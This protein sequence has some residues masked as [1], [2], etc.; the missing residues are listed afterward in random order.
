[1]KKFL[2]FSLI[3][4]GL[5]SVNV[6]SV[7]AST[8]DNIPSNVIEKADEKVNSSKYLINEIEAWEIDLN[9][10]ETKVIPKN[11]Y[12]NISTR[13]VPNDGFIYEFDHYDPDECSTNWHYK[14]AGVYRAANYSSSST[15]NA[16]YTQSSTTTTQWNVSGNISAQ[17]KIGT[18]FLGEITATAGVSVGRSKTWSSGTTYGA[19]FTVAPRTV[20][21]LTNYQ[22]GVNSG[23][24]LYWRK[25]SP[26]G[27]SIM[28][29]YKESANGTAIDLSRINIELTDSETM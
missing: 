27:I 6:S 3:S 23:G 20:N 21:Y 16:A 17:A 26:T 4:L 13:A 12:S 1:M 2:V 25:Y 19:S 22:V 7:S 8:V 9:G 10:N 11:L 14:V 15:L 28:G 5:L 18:S 24:Y 29:W